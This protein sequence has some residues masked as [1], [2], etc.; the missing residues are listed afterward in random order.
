MLQIF[1]P[2]EYRLQSAVYFRQ[3]NLYIRVRLMKVG[4]KRR[5]KT[6]L[7]QMLFVGAQEIA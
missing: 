7:K 1:A 2:I 3:P 6:C 4:A 5:K